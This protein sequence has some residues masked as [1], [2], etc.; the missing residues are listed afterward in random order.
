MPFL[1]AGGLGGVGILKA[2]FVWV[3]G[4]SGFEDA[5]D[6]VEELTHDG[7]DDLFGAFAIELEAISEFLEQWIEDP[8]AH[9]W[10]EKA[11]T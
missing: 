4:H 8:G 6:L 10:H 3:V 1:G 11:A 2:T 7:D 5:V 9:G